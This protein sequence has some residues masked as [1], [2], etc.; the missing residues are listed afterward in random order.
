MGTLSGCGEVYQQFTT[1]RPWG[2]GDTPEG[3]EM[4]RKGWSDGCETGMSAYGNGRYRAAY[5][6]TQDPN[7]IDNMEYYR[8]WKDGQV[9]CRWYTFRWLRPAA[10]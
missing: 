7:L 5:S 9:Y 3:S 10:Q 8:A 1:P 2:I 6:F 4:F